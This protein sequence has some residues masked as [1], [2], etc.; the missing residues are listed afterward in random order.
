MRRALLSF[1]ALAALSG[2]G[3]QR[4][5][6]PDVAK[7]SLP[8]RERVTVRYPDVGITYRAP[9]NWRVGAGD[10][11]PLVST[12]VS[13]SATVAIWRYDRAEPL[14]AA[15]KDLRQAR[16]DLIETVKR[17]D[18]KAKITTSKLTT[19]RGDDA[20]LLLGT[21]SIAGRRR[22]VRSLHIF[23]DKSEV[24]VDAYSQPTAFRV[25]DRAVFRPL[26][27]SLRITEPKKKKTA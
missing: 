19:F 5:Q 25:L 27:A 10:A 20:I 14:P 22:Q 11:A 16:K 23:K 17:R 13:G 21:E 15:K 18:P 6:P 2:C 1:L 4:T 9:A 3:N 12:L 8:A 7:P 26:I 24:V